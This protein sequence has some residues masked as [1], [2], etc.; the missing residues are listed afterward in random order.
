MCCANAGGREAIR[1]HDP[2]ATHRLF[3]MEDV[4]A[5]IASIRGRFVGTLIGVSLALLVN[6]IARMIALHLV[7]QIAIGVA[8]CA[9]A[10]MGRPLIRVCLWT[11]SLVL[12]TVASGPAPALVALTRGSEVVLGDLSAAR[13]CRR[14]ETWISG[15]TA[16]RESDRG[17]FRPYF[18]LLSPAPLGRPSSPEKAK[19][20]PN[21]QN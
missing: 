15:E 19:L 5:T 3:A 20:N 2:R 1:L 17:R 13:A 12:I 11:C 10:A 7:L 4:T 18:W 21:L 14:G 9:A 8:I 16:R 6:S